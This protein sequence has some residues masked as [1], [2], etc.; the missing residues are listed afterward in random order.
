M[1]MNNLLNK[2]TV[3]KKAA[4][5]AQGLY[6]ED[7]YASNK[8]LE[9]LKARFDISFK[10][11]VG[12]EKVV[13]SAD[14]SSAGWDLESFLSRF[15]LKDI[16]KADWWVWTFSEKKLELKA[17]I[18]AGGESRKVFYFMLISSNFISSSLWI[19]ACGL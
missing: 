3:L 11:A 4:S 6:V 7:F 2:E 5:Y 15:R 10:A 9:R 16:Y 12:K 1:R 13:T 17:K 19:S 14:M 18:Y 8:W